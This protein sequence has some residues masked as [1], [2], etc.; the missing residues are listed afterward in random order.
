MISDDDDIPLSYLVYVVAM[1]L[2]IAIIVIVGLV[3]CLR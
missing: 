2:A 3:L 1:L